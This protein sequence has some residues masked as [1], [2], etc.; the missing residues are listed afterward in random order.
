M[1]LLPIGWAQEMSEGDILKTVTHKTEICSIKVHF[2]CNLAKL[3]L[4]HLNWFPRPIWNVT[5]GAPL[6]AA[7][8][9]CRPPCAAGALSPVLASA[10]APSPSA[11]CLSRPSWPPVASA[12]ACAP[13]PFEP[14][15]AAAR[16]P[17]SRAPP[18]RAPPAAPDGGPYEKTNR[19]RK[20]QHVEQGEEMRADQT[21]RAV[22]NLRRKC[23]SAV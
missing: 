15:A 3:L 9:A 12:S 4:H 19:C 23:G 10:S 5:F 8:P 11:P 13:R 2:F 18:G 7:A 16:R 1:Y 22:A 21:H 6:A 20:D 14:P 17:T